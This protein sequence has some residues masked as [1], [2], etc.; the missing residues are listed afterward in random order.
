MMTVSP[1]WG[2]IIV[3]GVFVSCFFIAGFNGKQDREDL[4]NGSS[5]SD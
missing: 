5:D 4:D 3:I 1:G 2:L